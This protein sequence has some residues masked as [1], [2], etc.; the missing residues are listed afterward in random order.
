MQAKMLK[1]V[2]GA[3]K[4]HQCK[5]YSG[6]QLAPSPC[7]KLK[8]H[9]QQHDSDLFPHSSQQAPPPPQANQDHRDLKQEIEE[10][11]EQQQDS[12]DE[13]TITKE[14]AYLRQET[15]CLRQEQESITR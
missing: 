8:L 5:T 12:K 15:E 1:T 2:Q 3:S 14:L 10:L 4:A 11:E 7:K 9:S 13:A 6:V